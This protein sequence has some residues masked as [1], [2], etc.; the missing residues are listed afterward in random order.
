MMAQRHKWEDEII[1][2][3]SSYFVSITPREVKEN[4]KNILSGAMHYLNEIIVTLPEFEVL[5][6][7]IGTI[8]LQ[9]KLVRFTSEH[10][11]RSFS[12]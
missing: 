7:P 8:L 6:R 10:Q 12:G 5:R 4:M 11:L 1:S 3:R 9:I 2:Q